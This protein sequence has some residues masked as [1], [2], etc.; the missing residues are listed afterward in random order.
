MMPNREYRDFK[1]AQ[2]FMAAHFSSDI[3]LRRWAH[4]NAACVINKNGKKHVLSY[5][6][7]KITELKK[8]MGKKKKNSMSLDEACRT[9]KVRKKKLLAA[10]KKHNFKSCYRMGC[11]VYLYK[12]KDIEGAIDLE[13]I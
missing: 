9:Y 5:D 13:K 10:L 4:K 1:W 11:G 2:H 3:G 6:V 7:G 8:E 12:I